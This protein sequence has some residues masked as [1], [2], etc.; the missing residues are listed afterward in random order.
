M[1]QLKNY[2]TNFTSSLKKLETA[3]GKN[4][5]KFCLALCGGYLATMFA[6][7][8]CLGTP[9]PISIL[10]IVTIVTVAFVSAAIYSVLI[11]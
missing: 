4:N 3:I 6:I 11:A 1:K 2:F 10:P 5:G 9:L 8:L 7:V